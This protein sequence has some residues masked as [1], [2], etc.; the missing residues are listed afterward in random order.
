[1]G[2]W[3]LLVS[4]TSSHLDIFVLRDLL[5]RI[6]DY[7]CDEFWPWYQG[8][9]LHNLGWLQKAPILVP[10]QVPRVPIQALRVLMQ[11]PRVPI[12]VPV[13]TPNEYTHPLALAYT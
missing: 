3:P 6:R 1:V 13:S 5:L 11:V 10:I 12:Q 9:L 4:S 8:T 2:R 7:L